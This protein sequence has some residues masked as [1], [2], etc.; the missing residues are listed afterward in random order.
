[1]VR[2][3]ATFQCEVCG[4]EA[5]GKQIEFDHWH[6]PG[7]WRF[8]PDGWFRSYGHDLCPICSM[9]LKI[10]QRVNKAFND[11]IYRAKDAGIEHVDP[12]R[13]LWATASVYCKCFP[14]VNNGEMP[15]KVG[16]P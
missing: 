7:P 2:F 11:T 16:R 10:R 15:Q 8:L 5:P 9:E 14:E 1:M 3:T 6:N 13:E 4:A 12:W